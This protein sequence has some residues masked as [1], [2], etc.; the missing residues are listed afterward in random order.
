MSI[1]SFRFFFFIAALLAAYFLC[2]RKWQW[3][4]L[5][6]A[7]FLF[8]AAG[9]V[10]YLV[11][12]LFT[13]AVVFFAALRIERIAG[14]TKQAVGRQDSVEA[15]RAVRQSGAAKKRAVSTVAVL[16]VVGVWVVLK[17]GN[18]I[19]RNVNAVL[20]WFGPGG[21]SIPEASFILPL[22]IS[23]YTF[24][25][26]GYLVDVYRGK[27]PAER[28]FW[29]FALFVSYFPHII[30]GPFSRFDTLGQTLFSE[31]S[32][33][34]D[35]C[36]QGAG[37]ILWGIFKKLIVA[38]KIGTAVTMIYA[39]PAAYSGIHILLVAVFYS[40]QT[41]A[42][43]TGYMD[44]V[45][46]VSHIMG[47]E[48]AENFRQPYFARSVEE[49]WRRWHITLGQWVKDYV[50]F[51]LS[52]SRPAKR[53]GQWARRR[54]GPRMGKLLPFYFALFFVWTAT[55]LWHGANWTFLIWGWLNFAV[56]LVSMQ[57][58]D[59]YARLRARLGIKSGAK[60][61]ELFR[62]LRT[63]ALVSF[64]RFFSRADS[65]GAAFAMLRRAFSGLHLSVLAHPSL[66][67]PGMTTWSI[68]AVAAGTGMI[69]AVDVLRELGKW[70]RVKEKCPVLVRNAVYVGLIYALILFAGATNDLIGGFMYAKF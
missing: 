34:Y 4:V 35:R 13:I 37:R 36:C 52:L 26:V 57:L 55:G 5:L 25:A 27:Y 67:F 32:F 44:I 7:N 68:A 63:F 39:D 56:I 46:G 11:F 38:D 45:C 47:V 42:D 48:L 51:P 30:Q 69:V 24:H 59:V 6:A 64:F 22:G 53:M 10:R 1:T 20:A 18:F 2:P 8:Y 28:S 29:R 50:F 33:S 9:G 43:F 49:F 12:L 70:E 3:V 14:D 66:L 61:W 54:L 65:I 58:E 41:Y 23:F 16:A 62:I 15:K 21:H 31:H 40:I 19:I 17:Y 60:W